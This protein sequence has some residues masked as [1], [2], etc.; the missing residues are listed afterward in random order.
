MPRNALCLAPSLDLNVSGIC[1]CIA[2]FFVRVQGAEGRLLVQALQNFGGLTRVNFDATTQAAQ[3]CI[4]GLQRFSNEL[5]VLKGC[6]GLRPIAW[7]HNV[8]AAHGPCRCRACQ[9]R[10]VLPAQVT[11]EPNH[12]TVHEAFNCEACSDQCLR[13]APPSPTRLQTWRGLCQRW[14]S[15]V[16][17]SVH[18]RWICSDSPSCIA[19]TWPVA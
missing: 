6:V 14:H 17:E 7:L 11:F 15:G 16:R 18:R 13:A 12:L 19:Q 5:K 10:V 1:P 9:G 4:Q 3:M 2:S 8:D